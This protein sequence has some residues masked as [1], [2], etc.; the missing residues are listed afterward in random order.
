M[1]LQDCVWETLYRII[2]KTMLRERRHFIAAL[3]FSTQIYSYAPSN[4]IPA[5]KAAMDK[6]WEET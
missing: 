6:E 3:Q 1:N 5:A 2:M 4:E